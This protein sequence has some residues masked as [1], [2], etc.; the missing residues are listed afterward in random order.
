MNKS[1]SLTLALA[2]DADFTLD[3]DTVS[4]SVS[5]ELA[6]KTESGRRVFGK[7]SG[8]YSIDTTSGSVYIEKN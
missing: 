4:G 3:F 2:A 1:A 6:C 5:S 8:E 7:G